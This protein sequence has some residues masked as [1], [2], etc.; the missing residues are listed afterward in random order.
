MFSTE[1]RK[2]HSQVET[3]FAVIFRYQK[4][5]ES[6]FQKFALI[7]ASSFEM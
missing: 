7:D 4:Q 3:S 1:A 5:I 2:V 6:L